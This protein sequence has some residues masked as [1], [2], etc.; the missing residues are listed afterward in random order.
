M[1]TVKADS[2][3]SRIADVPNERVLLS[4]DNVCVTYGEVKELALTF[5][6]DYRKLIGKHCALVS[7]DRASLALFLPAIDN[8]STST[9]LLPNDLKAA[10]ESFYRSAGVEYVIH[11]G[12]RSVQ[13]VEEC[14]FK[15]TEQGAV[16]VDGEFVLATSGTT[17][18]PK[19]VSYS[20]NSLTATAVKNIERGGEFV[21]GLTY[22]I[23]RFA[24]LQVYLQAILS[25]STVV[26]SSS[27]NSVDA[28]VSCYINSKVNSLS[29]TP[30]F[31]RKLLMHKRHTDIPLKRI[32][33]GGEISHQSVLNA[34]GTSFPSARIVHIYASTEAGVGFA[35]KDMQE[36]FP[37]SLL[38]SDSTSGL[39]LKVVDDMLWV[40]SNNGCR[41]F[42]NSSIETDVDGFISTGDLVKVDGD[43]VYFLGRDSGSINV[44]GNKVMPE[45]VEAILEGCTLVSIAKISAKKSSI[46][47]SIISAEVVLSE[48]EGSLTKA[49]AKKRIIA[50]CKALLQSFEVPALIKFVDEIETNATG[51]KNRK[52]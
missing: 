29:A 16:N 6:Q 31:W 15:G 11:V 27:C 10:P 20:L 46:M 18:T 30:S 9:L 44:G 19:L 47:G 42:L 33:L 52:I 28:L 32:T 34:L 48:L 38:N 13:S 24:G 45:K 22:D 43:R 26:I 25:G 14:S 36:G 49:E 51:K 1:K 4:L 50:H 17:G 41:K 7:D 3:L 8:L 5:A 35:V 2:L 12:E 40:K 37:A 39:G 23:N 21:W